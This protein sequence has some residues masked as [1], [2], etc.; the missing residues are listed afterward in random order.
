MK[1]EAKVG[2]IQLPQ[3]M[4]TTDTVFRIFFLLLVAIVLTLYLLK[5]KE[6]REEV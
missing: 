3:L 4:S 2:F 5:T 6:E 1:I